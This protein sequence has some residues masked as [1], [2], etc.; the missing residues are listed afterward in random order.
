MVSSLEELYSAF[1]TSNTRPAG[2]A[3]ALYPN[4]FFEVERGEVVAFLPVSEERATSQRAQFIDIPAAELAV[5]VHE[6][7]FSQL[8]QSYGALGTFVAQRELGVSGPIREYYVVSSAETDDESESGLEVG[9]PIF[10]TTPA[11]VEESNNKGDT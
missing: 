11:A 4:E 8:D 7:S 9:W 5:A 6:G 3:A 10:H 2:P 1:K